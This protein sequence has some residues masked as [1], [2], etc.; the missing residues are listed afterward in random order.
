MTGRDWRVPTGGLPAVT[1]AFFQTPETRRPHRNAA[2]LAGGWE[3][4]A[5]PCSASGCEHPNVK[6]RQQRRTRPHPFQAGGV[7]RQLS[8]TLLWL[9]ASQARQSRRSRGGGPLSFRGGT[10]SSRGQCRGVALQGTVPSPRWLPFP[11]V[12]SLP[13]R[14]EPRA[15]S[16]QCV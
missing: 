15:Q 14:L 5:R 13:L 10:L 12:C 8:H 16:N 6:P 9:D 3:P 7:H 2:Q 4:R 1:G 11:Q